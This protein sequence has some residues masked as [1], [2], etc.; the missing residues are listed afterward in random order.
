MRKICFVTCGALPVP[1]IKGGAIEQLIELLIN[2]NE[3]TPKF[4][5]TVV[6]C[7]DSKVEQEFKKYKYTHFVQLKHPKSRENKLW[8]KL[9]GGVRKLT[10]NDISIILPFNRRVRNFLCN[11]GADFDYII[12]EGCEIGVFSKPSK[13]YGT[14]K[15]VNHIHCETF[16]TPFLEDTFGH[17]IVVG[18]FIK[19][20][21][22]SSMTK[23]DM[24]I[25]VLKNRIDLSKFAKNIHLKIKVMIVGSSDF[26]GAQMTD[27]QSSV[28][29]MAVQHKDR[30]VF[31]GY[32]DN[33]NLYRYHKSADIAVVPSICE[34]AFNIAILE[35]LASGIPT[36]ATRSGGLVEEGT[37][38]TTLFIDKEHDLVNSIRK[39]IME[40]YNNPSKLSVMSKNSV[41]RS[42]LFDKNMYLN[43]FENV[44]N[45]L[46]QNE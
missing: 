20:Q 24:S 37:S 1:A 41:E 30:V 32:I 7:C 31:T 6:E 43:E 2:E 44:I 4:E 35:F 12:S 29:N 33:M 14:D 21:F 26:K 36:I 15:F 10:G 40:L 46:G 34:E 3:R 27:Y 13:M 45:Q 5:F 23:K 18:D 28:C 42:R 19:K 39:A 16:S 11:K 8:W 25:S 38:A 9:R 17:I 22:M